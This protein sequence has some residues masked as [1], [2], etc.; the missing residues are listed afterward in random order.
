VVLV[1]H[2][3]DEKSTKYKGVWTNEILNTPGKR[4]GAV[5]RSQR[6]YQAQQQKT[7]KPRPGQHKKTAKPWKHLHLKH[8]GVMDERGARRLFKNPESSRI[9]KTAHDGRP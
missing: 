2:T 3:L 6:R 7:V 5:T 1:C 8:G 9:K 4:G